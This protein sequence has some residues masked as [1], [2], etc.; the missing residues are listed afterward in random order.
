MCQSAWL[1]RRNKNADLENNQQPIYIWPF[2]DNL[3][4]I[5][6]T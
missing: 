4:F 6:L 1:L 3:F 2:L 5:I